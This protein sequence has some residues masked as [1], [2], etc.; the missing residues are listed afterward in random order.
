MKKTAILATVVLTAGMHPTPGT[1]ARVGTIYPKEALEAG[2]EGWVD[3]AYW[4]DG[5]CNL[6]VEVIAAEPEGVFEEAAQANFRRQVTA[7]RELV[8]WSR[9]PGYTEPDGR[10]MTEAEYRLRH[11]AVESGGPW[12]R[13]KALYLDMFGGERLRCRFDAE[14]RFVSVEVGPSEETQVKAAA[15]LRQ[16]LE[17]LADRATQRFTFAIE[18]EDGA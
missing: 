17:F 6:V 3:L 16:E 11:E 14:E 5:A 15:D 4:V 12:P 18:K 9:I 13:V 8:D 10:P 1:S 2:I 7:E